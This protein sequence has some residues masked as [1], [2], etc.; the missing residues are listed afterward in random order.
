MRTL[1]M[2]IVNSMLL[3]VLHAT[4]KQGYV[5]EFFN[6]KKSM[7]ANK[8]IYSLNSEIQCVHRCLRSEGCGVLNYKGE[9]D[10]KSISNNCEVFDVPSDHG[11]CSSV[12]DV[13]WKSVIFK[14][15]TESETCYIIFS[16]FFSF[17]LFSLV[18]TIGSLTLKS[19]LKA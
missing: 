13:G 11:S 1:A 16:F 6:D 4:T 9:D 3:H 19:V 5:S 7:C 15:S 10:E 8:R 2:F 18:R 12:K 14:V 17:F